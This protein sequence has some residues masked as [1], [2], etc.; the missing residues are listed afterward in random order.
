[1]LVRRM[2][3]GQ[4][5]GKVR[6]NLWKLANILVPIRKGVVRLQTAV[7]YL[8]RVP[9]SES[10]GWVMLTTVPSVGQRRSAKLDDF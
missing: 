8:V 10:Q 9:Y 5:K 1:M 4:R 7:A 6:S 3:K 2:K